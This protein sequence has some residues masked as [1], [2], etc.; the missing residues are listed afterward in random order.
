MSDKRRKTEEYLTSDKVQVNLNYELILD[1]SA[2][3]IDL[4]LILDHFKNKW[5]S[6]Y[7]TKEP[8]PSDLVKREFA[9][10][11][12]NFIW[13]LS[14]SRFISF[15]FKDL[16]HLDDFFLVNNSQK[17]VSTNSKLKF[18]LLAKSA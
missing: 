8:I 10:E 16:S 4:K 18:G 5:S 7:R 17:Y 13:N 15:T 12:F 1:I 9:V 2:E 3:V 14:S 11:D 6:K